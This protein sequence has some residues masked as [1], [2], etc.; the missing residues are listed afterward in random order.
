MVKDFNLF[1]KAALGNFNAP[2]PY[3]LRLASDPWPHV[4]EIPTGLG[5]TAAIV[6]SWMY[7]RLSGDRSTPRRLVYCLPM[8]VLVEQT[9]NNINTWIGKLSE[10]GILPQDW[11]LKVYTL[12]GGEIENDWDRYP[13]NNAILVGTQDQ[14]LSRA[15]NRGYSMSRFRW[16]IDFGFLNNDCLWVMDEVQLMGVGLATTA[17]LQAFRQ[18]LGTFASVHSVWMSATLQK[19]WLNTVDFKPLASELRELK[20]STKDREQPSVSKRINAKKPLHK[21]VADDSAPPKLASE[22]LKIHKAGT[23]TLVVVNTV[24]RA[25]DVYNLI[26]KKKPMAELSLIHSRFRPADREKALEKLFAKPAGHGSICISTQVVEAGVDISATTLITDLAPWSSLVQRFGR[27]N[28]YGDN[29]NAQ[30][31]WVELNT[32]KKGSELPYTEPA[33]AESAAILDASDDVGSNFLRPVSSQENFKHVLRKKDLIDLFDTTPDLSGMDVDISRF[34]RESDDMDVHVFWRDLLKEQEPYKDVRS[35]AHNELCSVSVRSIRAASEIRPFSWDHLEKQW[36]RPASISPGMTLMLDISDGC[37]D[38]EIGW[39][40]SKSD[41]PEPIEPNTQASEGDDDDRYVTTQWQTLNA[42]TKEVVSSLTYILTNCNFE[43]D[44]IKAALID[45]A[46]WHDAGKTHEVFQSAIL[47]DC[48]PDIDRSTLWA[49]TSNTRIRYGRK[50]FRHELASAIAMIENG[51]SDL[52]AYLAAAHHGK[53]R[54]SIRS[55]P[56]ENSPDNPDIRFARGVWEGDIVPEVVLGGGRVVPET[57]MDLSYME[58]G[59]GPKGP[60]WTS[61]MIGLRDDKSL[62]PFRLSYLEGLL[63]AADWRASAKAGE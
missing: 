6:L 1:F 38:P 5:K 59:D 17:Q 18:N 3:Q 19:D 31:Y 13:E 62:G 48:P 46:Y 28:R 23:R 15:L 22:I 47:E 25:I 16:P 51:L 4:V 7:K 50:G 49:K 32:S 60:S 44:G 36:G 56:H 40:G 27:C 41:V 61:R 43:E 21:I 57:V 30:V 63:R 10:A 11:G 24:R 8:R 26:K 55:L 35:P 33:L 2:Y 39:T 37:Y 52:S 54:L 45:A 20:L 12:K 58:F 14:L 42:H 9:A 29:E 34:I 53:V